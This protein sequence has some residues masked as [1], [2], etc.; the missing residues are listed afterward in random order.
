MNPMVFLD[1]PICGRYITGHI[2]EKKER[3]NIE[4]QCPCCFQF[5]PEVNEE[6]LERAKELVLVTE[7]IFYVRDSINR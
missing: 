6:Y 2:N 1:C 4:E 5:N 3:T 7:K